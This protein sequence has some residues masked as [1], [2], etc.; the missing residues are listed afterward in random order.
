MRG[1]DIATQGLAMSR[2]GVAPLRVYANVLG[3]RRWPSVRTAVGQDPALS[4]Q[5]VGGRVQT[6]RSAPGHSRA[7]V[8]ATRGRGSFL[9]SSPTREQRR[10]DNQPGLK[11]LAMAGTGPPESAIY[12][13]FP[14]RLASLGSV[15]P[16]EERRKCRP[17]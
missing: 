11:P 17:M 14:L 2:I 4:S 9:G 1:L 15:D 10:F 5:I 13:T 6:R 16:R 3:P 8:A 7:L 12:T